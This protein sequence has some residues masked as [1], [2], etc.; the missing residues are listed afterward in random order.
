MAQFKVGTQVDILIG[1]FLQGIA[2]T[3]KTAANLT[4]KKYDKDS[5]DW[6]DLTAT[7]HYTLDEGSLGYY[8]LSIL[9]AVNDT[10][11]E[12]AIYVSSA[13]SLWDTQ[14]YKVDI[15]TN[16]SGDNYGILNSG[17]YGNAA[18]NTAIG[19]ITAKLPD[20]GDIAGVSDIAV[21]QDDPLAVLDVP[22]V[23]LIPASSTN[24]YRIR[25][26]I[27]NQSG[28][29]D[30]PDS[31]PTLTATAATTAG[32]DRSAN[33]GAAAKVAD[34]IYDWIYTVGTTHV[35]EPV[36]FVATYIEATVTAA[37]VA[38]TVSVSDETTLIDALHTA[39]AAA[40]ADSTTVPAA[41]AALADKLAWDMAQ[42]LGSAETTATGVVHK[43]RAGTAI[44]TRTVADDGSTTTL[45]GVS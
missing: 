6:E 44:G 35:R 25:L 39:L 38:R 17:T 11:G 30:E 41:G 27:K 9:A 18:L 36:R 20:S 22:N 5:T 13:T 42:R 40:R 31:A 28:V 43:N 1:L 21:V 45:S 24:T 32:G 33:L 37:P 29:P 2:V 15:V 34:G 14:V 26:I 23:M 4:V 19:L 10:A 16:L 8:K 7:T 3:G 12:L